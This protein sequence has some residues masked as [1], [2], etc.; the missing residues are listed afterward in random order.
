MF[1]DK[2]LSVRLYIYLSLILLLAGCSSNEEANI[3]YNKSTVEITNS[4]VID[5]FIFDTGSSHSVIFQDTGNIPEGEPVSRNR[6]SDTNNRGRVLNLYRVESISVGSLEIN[7]GEFL[8]IDKKSLPS[9]IHSYKGIIG[10]DIIDLGN[11]LIDMKNKEV[12]VINKDSIYETSQEGLR[13]TYKIRN[14][15]PE[16]T[17]KIGNLLL[18]NMIIDTGSQAMV[19]LPSGDTRELNKTYE[20]V[21][22]D[23]LLFSG[24]YNNSITE[25]L[26]HEYHDITLNNSFFIDTLTVSEVRRERRIGF[27]LFKKYDFVFI[28]TQNQGIYLYK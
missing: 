7:N 6:I 24:L 3:S 9:M 28:D 22:A 19:E 23:T 2:I 8:Y 13:L 21:V 1:T 15:L 27:G 14:F 18:Q 25:H 5:G 20:S 11:W 4:L 12:T 16:A 17:L 26:I 10:M